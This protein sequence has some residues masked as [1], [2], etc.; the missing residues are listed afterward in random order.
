[1]IIAVLKDFYLFFSYNYEVFG[2]CITTYT[3]FG[4]INFLQGGL[5]F[6]TLKELG[7]SLLFGRMIAKNIRV[8][9]NYWSNIEIEQFLNYLYLN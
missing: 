5:R 7:L 2:E 8:G 3:I 1:V 4:S 9:F 6:K